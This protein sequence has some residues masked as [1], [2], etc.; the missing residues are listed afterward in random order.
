MRKDQVESRVV[1]VEMHDGD[2]RH[3]E[4]AAQKLG[5]PASEF[6]LLSASL[7]ASVVNGDD[8]TLARLDENFTPR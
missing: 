3:V 1:V 7:I 2:Y 6:L 4:S 5:Y 8:V